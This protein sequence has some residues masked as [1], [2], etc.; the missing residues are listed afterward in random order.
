M[1]KSPR[2]PRNHSALQGLALAHKNQKRGQSLFSV[3]KRW[4]LYGSSSLRLLY[5]LCVSGQ[6]TAFRDRGTQ[7]KTSISLPVGGKIALSYF[8]HQSALTKVLGAHRGDSVHK[9]LELSQLPSL[10]SPAKDGAHPPCLPPNSGEATAVINCCENR[11]LNWKQGDSEPHPKSTWN[12]LGSLRSTY[13]LQLSPT[14]WGN[15]GLGSN[16]RWRELW[17]KDQGCALRCPTNLL[18][19]MCF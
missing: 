3:D 6:S 15:S 7:K 2:H 13:S 9:C 17:E 14:K 10:R 5:L 18:I 12:P 4:H 8:I 19:S 11:V 16:G 1:T